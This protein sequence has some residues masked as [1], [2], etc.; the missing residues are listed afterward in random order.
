MFSEDELELPEGD[1]TFVEGRDTIIILRLNI[2]EVP[3]ELVT[4][5]TVE[6]PLYSKP[7]V[8][9][10]CN[11]VNVDSL[12]Q[13]IRSF[14]N[15]LQLGEPIIMTIVQWL[16]ENFSIFKLLQLSSISVPFSTIRRYFQL[17]NQNNELSSEECAS[18]T[19]DSNDSVV[20]ARYW[21]YS[22]HLRSNIKRKDIEYIAKQLDLNGFSC[23]GKPGI[24][25]VEGEANSCKEFWEKVRGWTW[26]HI[27]VRH[28]EESSEGSDGFLRLEKFK[29]II[30]SS[31]D[32]KRIEL[33][34]MKIYLRDHDLEYGFA[35]LLNL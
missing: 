22:H 5:C 25:V 17:D 11:H 33:G 35:I 18:K 7:N 8:F 27:V 28:T 2:D 6:Y 20:Y 23:P 12:N 9:V 31:N 29:E 14:V 32:G 30:F 26:K 21:I 16:Q 19:N 24:I 4:Q 1:S 34:D 15:E 3:V 13:Q 10:R